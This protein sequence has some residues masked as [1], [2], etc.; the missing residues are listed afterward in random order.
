VK[1]LLFL[2]DCSHW[3]MGCKWRFYVEPWFRDKDLVE[4][5]M[6]WSDK[7]LRELFSLRIGIS[8]GRV[9]FDGVILQV[10]KSLVKNG[11]G[12]FGVDDVSALNE[13]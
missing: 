8:L 10:R 9:P 7:K 5:G 3:G 13:V 2:T 1:V 11:K 12:C 6:S 4:S